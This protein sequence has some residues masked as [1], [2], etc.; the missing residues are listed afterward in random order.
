MGRLKPGVGIE[1]A[2]ADL[3]SIAHRIHR[4]NPDGLFP[5]E[6][7]AIAPQT[8]LDSLIGNFRKTLYVLFAAAMLLLLIACSNVANLLLARATARGREIAVR[9]TLGA[10]RGHLIRQLLV[11][12]FILATAATAAGCAFAYF[13]LNVVIAL[14]PAGT[15]PEETVIHMNAPVLFLSLGLTILTTIFCG[16]APALH[17]VRGDLQ[18]RL[19]GGGK[20]AGGN[21]R[22]SKVRGGLVVIE[23]ALSSVLLISAGLLMRSFLILTTW[24]SASIRRMFS[25]SRSVCRRRITRIS[26]AV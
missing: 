6:K 7:F 10:T 25:T 2:A 15:L 3:D 23:V 26:L 5:E 21:F 18:P 17:V 13:G 14:I 16:L 12:S 9:A 11:E 8:L 19:A 24:T 1:A 4:P 20:G 22:H